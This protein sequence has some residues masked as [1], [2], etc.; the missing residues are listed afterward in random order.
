MLMNRTEL[1]FDAIDN[2]ECNNKDLNS[3]NYFM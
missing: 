3:M 1:Y 2:V